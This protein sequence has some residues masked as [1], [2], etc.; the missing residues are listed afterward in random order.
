MTV[1]GPG[2]P[3]RVATTMPRANATACPTSVKSLLSQATA[4]PT[5]SHQPI[6]LERQRRGT[7]PVSVPSTAVAP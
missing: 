6:Q 7:A 5:A 1:H 2:L 4:T 3:N